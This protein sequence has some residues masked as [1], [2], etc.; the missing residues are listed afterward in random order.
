MGEG[1]KMQ[2]RRALKEN[3]PVVF[4]LALAVILGGGGSRY[5]VL[6]A[7]V[8]IACLGILVFRWEDAWS[9]LMALPA[10][11]R[12][13][14][15]LSLLLPLC[16]LVPLPPGIWHAMPGREYIASSLALLG[17]EGAWF[18]WTFERGRTLIAFASLL[19]PLAILALYHR[20]RRNFSS[21]QIL[22]ATIVLLGLLN[23]LV[24]ALQVLFEGMSPLP[25]PILVDGRAY[26]LFASHN[27][28]GLFFICALAALAGIKELPVIGPVP[29]AL[30]LLVGT[31]LLL[32]VLLTQSRS[33]IALAATLVLAVVI[34]RLH[35][36]NVVS[37]KEF[38]TKR[39][40]LMAIAGVNLGLGVIGA[41][42]LASKS[43]IGTAIGRFSDLEDARPSI[44]GDTL[45]AIREF[46]P[47]GT[48]MGSFDEVFQAFESL[49]TIE[50]SFARRAHNDYLELGLEAGL[51]GW[52]LLAGWLVWIIYSIWK[53]RR[54][55][56]R[57]GIFSVG[58][59]FACVAMQSSLD[60]PLR[61]QGMLAVVGAMVALLCACLARTKRSKP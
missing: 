15:L 22:L 21:E 60:Y 19:P 34:S 1:A 3:W 30:K 27:T 54:L 52:V 46:F 13:L 44:W 16:Q 53:S 37:V 10:V 43:R 59:M 33:S 32:G 7:V 49:E 56:S 40:A 24:A 61:S 38:F 39:K 29:R 17:Q 14:T 23:F 51:I 6:N 55:S 36:V 4:M 48:G 42:V 57:S 2:S 41:Y 50:P 12:S 9:N 20:D 47:F 35:G 5:G 58:V 31:L 18:P 26:G 11:V 8:Q 45:V 25:Y 28:S